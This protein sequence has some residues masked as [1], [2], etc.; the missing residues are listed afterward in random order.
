PLGLYRG[1]LAGIARRRSAAMGR[2]HP[3]VHGVLPQGTQHRGFRLARA[4]LR[5]ALN[6]SLRP[7]GELAGT[8][9]FARR[10]ARELARGRDVRF[11]SWFLE[12]VLTHP[13]L[14]LSQSQV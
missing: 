6:R 5:L 2:V 9:Y 7:G 10:N 11:L 1:R 4:D 14:L 12:P 13:R 3:W 8:R